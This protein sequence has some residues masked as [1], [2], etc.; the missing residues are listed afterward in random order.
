MFYLLLIRKQ[1]FYLNMYNFFFDFI[2]KLKLMLLHLL[3]S[4]HK[5]IFF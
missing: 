5:E 4:L 1:I 3:S 2:R